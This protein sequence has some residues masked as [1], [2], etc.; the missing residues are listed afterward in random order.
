[1]GALWAMVIDSTGVPGLA[2]FSGIANKDVCSQ[3][4]K[5]LYRCRAV[6][7]AKNPA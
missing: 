7:G 2:Y 1:L 6:N 4:T 5:S 3:P